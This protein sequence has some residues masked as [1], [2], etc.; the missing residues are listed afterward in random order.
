MGTWQTRVQIERM[1]GAGLDP[2]PIGPESY[3]YIGGGVALVNVRALHAAE[4]LREV[5]HAR[6]SLED[7]RPMNATIYRL[8]GSG[9]FDWTDGPAAVR[10]RITGLSDYSQRYAAASRLYGEA[11]HAWGAELERVYGDDACNARYDRARHAAT[12]E[13]ARLRFKRDLR[14]AQ[15][16]GVVSS[17]EEV[18]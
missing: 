4:G 8:E 1:E 18:A 14:R 16:E 3:L 2:A 7:A 15:W 13:L 9:W 10:L 17:A 12:P 6:V 5:V 11:D